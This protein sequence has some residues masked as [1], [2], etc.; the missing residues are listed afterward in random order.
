MKKT[1]INEMEI[2]NES[3]IDIN[4]DLLVELQKIARLYL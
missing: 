3:K 4:S 1:K 2:E